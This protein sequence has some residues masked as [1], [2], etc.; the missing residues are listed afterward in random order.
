M[1]QFVQKAVASGQ[2]V[3]SLFSGL[4]KR[5]GAILGY[6]FRVG[7]PKSASFGRN[8]PIYICTRLTA[9]QGHL[10]SSAVTRFERKGGQM[11][12][13]GQFLP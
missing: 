8:H 5:D 2:I 7:S 13:F 4:S 12:I 11:S 10:T 1:G 9:C 3:P 6:S